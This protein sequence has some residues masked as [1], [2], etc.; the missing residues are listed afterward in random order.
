MSEYVF[1][2]G[3]D[4]RQ[5]PASQ[6]SDRDLQ[7]YAN[8]C[9]AAAPK[10]AAAAEL[11][12]RKNGGQRAPAPPAPPPTPAGTSLA[13]APAQGQGAPLSLEKLTHEPAIVT[14]RLAELS[15]QYHLVT[16]ATQVDALPIGFGV[17]VSLVRVDP[18]TSKDGPGEVYPMGGGKLG[19]SG[20]KI[21]DIG[22][23]VGVD[24][25]DEKSGRLDDGSDSRYCHY[26]AVGYVKNFDNSK[27]RI[28]GEVEIDVRPGGA[29]Y[30][31][32]ITKAES[33][34]RD[35][36]P[37]ILEL[38]KF[39]LRHAET[40]AKC[41]AVASLGIKRSYTATELAKP[42]AVARLMFTGHTDDPQLRRDFALL[43]A[44]HAI[45]GSSALYGEPRRLPPQRPAPL[46]EFQGHAPPPPGLT[47][48]DEPDYGDV[49]NFDYEAEGESATATPLPTNKT[50]ADAPQADAAQAAEK[51]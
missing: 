43:N 45:R 19:I 5:V 26:R 44:E 25:D 27:R 3:K 38:R 15:Q 11:Q 13:R 14:A 29:A 50:P 31:E 39:L 32:I 48:G 33:S 12:R 30:D 16:P 51:L 46:Q 22:S 18:N 47:A 6:M 7:W 49:G 24:W 8:E 40:K 4:K 28:Q 23:A 9:R 2:V 42:F 10:Q 20:F 1:S 35:P 37:Q 41:R 34:G 36:N 17:A 21:L